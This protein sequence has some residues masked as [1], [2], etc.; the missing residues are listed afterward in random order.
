[1]KGGIFM[2]VEVYLVNYCDEELGQWLSLPASNAEIKKTID[3]I[4]PNRCDRF[5]IKKYKSALGVTIPKDNYIYRLNDI[6]SKLNRISTNEEIMAFIEAFS[7]NIE[8]ILEKMQRGRYKYF[9]NKT[10]SELAYE[11]RKKI[12]S[13]NIVLSKT[14]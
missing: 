11:F 5:L 6:V 2:M 7:P 14:F 10:L 9:F 3:E 13:T 8:E 1:M 12:N 4:C